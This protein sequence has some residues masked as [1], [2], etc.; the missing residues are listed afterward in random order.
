MKRWRLEQLTHTQG[1]TT[2]LDPLTSWFVLAWD[3]FRAPVFPYDEALR[4]ARAVGVDLDAQ[5]VG[6][7]A[8]KKGSDLVLWDSAKRAAKGALGPPDG[9]RGMIDALH[10]AAHLG[11]TRTLE[12]A[13]EL[14][15]KTGV[16]GEPAFFAALEAVLEVLPVVED[17]HWHRP[18]R[19]TGARPAATSRRWRSSAGSPSPTQVDEPEQLRLWIEEASA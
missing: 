10:H 8:E 12:A 11:R 1:A 19:R 16:D 2:E 3:A 4:L 6:R 15:A 14:L 7:L 9:S 13:R 5:V 17:V 18:R